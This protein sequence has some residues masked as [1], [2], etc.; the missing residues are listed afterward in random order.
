MTEMVLSFQQLTADR[1]LSAGGKGGTLAQLFQANYPVP[2]GFVILPSAFRDDQISPEAWAQVCAQLERLREGDGRLTFAVRSSALSEDSALASFAGEFETVLDVRTDDEIRDAIREVRRSRWN[3]RVQAYS[4]A[5]G[6]DTAHEI[7]VVVQQLVQ[8]DFSGVLFTADPVTGDRNTMT[9]NFIRGLGDR[10]V[11]GE[12]DAQAFSLQ[13]PKGAYKG[14]PELQPYASKLHRIAIRLEKDMDGPQDIEWAIAEGRVY[15]LQ[16]RPITTLAAYDPITGEWNE[17]RTGDRLWLD[18]GGIY[19]EVMTPSSVSIW[20][21]W[22]QQGSIGGEYMLAFVG[23]RLYLNYSFSY[24]LMRRLGKSHE[25]VT[26]MLETRTGPLPDGVDV[27]VHH[28]S[29]L[30]FVRELLP[31]MIAGLSKQRRI[32]ANY[33]RI[34]DTAVDRCEQVEQKIQ[35]AQAGAEL[36]AIWRQDVM[37]LFDELI[38]LLDGNNDDYF[39]PFE[40]LLRSLKQVVDTDEAKA[41]LAAL[42][43]GAGAE[44]ATMGAMT[45]LAKVE[46]GEISREEYT[47]LYGHRHPNENEIAV[48]RPKE[49]PEWLEKRLEDHRRS[50]VDVEKL[51]DRADARFE[52]AWSEFRKQY[53]KQAQRVRGYIDNFNTALHKRESIRVEVTRSIGVMRHWYLRASE[54]LGMGDDIFFLAVQEVLDLLRGDESATAY[55]HTRREHYRKLTALPPYPVV[56]RGRFEPLQWAADPHRRTDY[57]DARAPLPEMVHSTDTVTGVAGSAGRVEGIVRFLG[58]VEDG[59]ELLPGEILLASTTNV[60][61]TPLFPKAAAVVTDIGAALSHAAIV[62]RELGIPAVVGCGDATMRL[63]SGDRVLVDGSHGAVQILQ[64]A[65]G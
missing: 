25:D 60:G 3:E 46:N 33:E 65:A 19:P 47:R 56:I 18:N 61:W 63:K 10:L 32:K 20:A 58:S 4:K 38:H 17:S 59:S 41:L 54:L 26:V 39:N 30:G 7:A 64:R 34:I 22:F 21:Q 12:A 6:I 49:D 11:A 50:P 62:A 57:Y 9:G 45:D 42:S 36:V 8:P 23:N 55:I 5:K 15:L 53:P 51:M 24:W 16:S 35:Q 28:I 43:G 13:K 37:L 48:P 44:L 2:D 52:A 31:K 14:P 1:Q 27:P 29:L 40:A